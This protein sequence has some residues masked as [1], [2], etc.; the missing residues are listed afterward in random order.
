[1][2][3]KY[4][5]Y[6]GHA[7]EAGPLFEVTWYLSESYIPNLLN[8][9]SRFGAG[10]EYGTQ[11]QMWRHFLT[12]FIARWMKSMTAEMG[13][14]GSISANTIHSCSS[15]RWGF[16]T[17]KPKH[18]KWNKAV[19]SGCQDLKTELFFDPLTL[20]RI[21]MNIFQLCVQ[22]CFQKYIWFSPCESP[23]IRA[24]LYFSC[25]WR[26]RVPLFW[27]WYCIYLFLFSTVF[28]LAPFLSAYSYIF[29]GINVNINRKRSSKYRF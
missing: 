13:C 28:C 21:K 15:G 1:M 14:E 29:G 17:T 27:R 18:L 9:D 23:S 11:Q 22:T 16:E 4:R 25:C 7:L 8:T 20:L 19:I 26:I 12:I 3:Y 5:S 6:K 2:S 10:I 24:S